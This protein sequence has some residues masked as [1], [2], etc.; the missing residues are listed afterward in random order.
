MER[1]CIIGIYI[2]E[3]PVYFPVWLK[4][5][6]NN[7]TIDFLII[8]NQDLTDLPNN[9]RYIKYDLSELNNIFSKKLGFDVN[10]VDP[11]KICDFKPCYGYIFEDEI[12][13]YDYWGHCDF[14]LIFGDLRCFFDKYHLYKYDKF[15]PM[16][17]LSLYR[18]TMSNN[19]KFM[20]EV[21]GYSSYKQILSSSQNFLFDE[22]KLIKIF[23]KSGK[24][25]EKIIYADINPKHKRYKMCTK[26]KYYQSIYDQFNKEYNPV[27]LKKQ[28]FV[29]ENGKIY[30]YYEQNNKILKREFIY[31][32]IQKR[33]WKLQGEFSNVMIISEDKVFNLENYNMY[34]NINEY[35]KYN[36]FIETKEK[37]EDFIIHCFDYFCRKIIKVKKEKIYIENK[38]E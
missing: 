5:C 22:F 33:K 17:H 23:Q 2:G 19:M 15:L 36:L 14:D 32:H 24:F 8:T 12:K 4:S 13:K 27:N 29:W 16:G 11:F 30:Q 20:E 37:I 26:L 9:V 6:E 1:I 18:N 35:N 7:P 34:S 10:I 3:L 21:K 31:I 38:G 25:Y 28:L